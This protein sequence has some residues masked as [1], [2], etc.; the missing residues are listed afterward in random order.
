[1]TQIE[2]ECAVA[3]ATG[4]SL[5]TIHRRGFGVEVREPGGPRPES[6]RLALDCPF[7]GRPVPYPGRTGG[8]SAALAECDRCDVYF[9][10]DEAEVYAMEGPAANA[11]GQAARVA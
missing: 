3:E 5:R 6:L 4:E 7:C 10:F 9:D 8:G 1:M 11:A 2:I